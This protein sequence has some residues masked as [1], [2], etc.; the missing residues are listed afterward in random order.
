MVS[1]FFFR[2]CS[3]CG[4]ND[5]IFHKNLST[6]SAN[7]NGELFW[8]SLSTCSWMGDDSFIP[9]IRLQLGFLFQVDYTEAKSTDNARVSSHSSAGRCSRNGPSHNR[10]VYQLFIFVFTLRA[11]FFRLTQVLADSR[12]LSYVMREVMRE[13]QEGT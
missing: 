7:M 2:C 8:F 4:M 9:L 6:I 1:T 3:L 12:N 11:I 13:V 10:H 5:K